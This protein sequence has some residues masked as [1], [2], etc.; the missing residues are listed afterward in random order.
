MVKPIIDSLWPQ[1]GG[2]AASPEDWRID[3]L[4]LMRG[5]E[6]VPARSIAVSLWLS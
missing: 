6:S 1:I 4:V 2:T 5:C 3:T